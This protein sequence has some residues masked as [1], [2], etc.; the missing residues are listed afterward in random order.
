MQH[1]NTLHLYESLIF[2]IYGIY[3]ICLFLYQTAEIINYVELD[4]VSVT[5]CNMFVQ[6]QHIPSRHK[7]VNLRR[8]SVRMVDITLCQI[9]L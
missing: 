5:A 1:F 8:F 2:Y 4:L 6:T 9:L 3:F 7:T